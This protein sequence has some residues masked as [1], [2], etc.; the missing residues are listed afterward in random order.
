MAMETEDG[1]REP[2]TPTFFRLPDDWDDLT[3]EEKKAWALSVS[4]R[5]LGPGT[6][7]PPP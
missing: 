7:I 6:E 5:L 4:D 2:R 3:E 1:T